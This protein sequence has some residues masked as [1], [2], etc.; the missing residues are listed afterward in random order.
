MRRG[1]GWHEP[2]RFARADKESARLARRSGHNGPVSSVRE[3]W[4]NADAAREQKAARAADIARRRG[5]ANVNRLR[6][7]TDDELITDAPARTSLSHPDHEME[8]ERRLKDSIQA[9]TAE[10]T[11]ARVWAA[12]GA[13]VIAVLTFVVIVLTVVLIKR[14]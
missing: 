4:S 12:W 13:A 8:M 9:L 1:S 11:K 10:T 2:S 3:W 6:A 5:V 7:L 14:G